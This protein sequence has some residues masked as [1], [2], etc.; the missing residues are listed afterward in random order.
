M[1]VFDSLP[2][3]IAKAWERSLTGG[4]A[5]LSRRRLL[6]ATGAAAGGAALA[7][8]GIPASDDGK[9]KG[10]SKDP[11][12][13]KKEKELIF[14]NWT[15]YIDVDDKDENKRP[16]LD[17]FQKESGIKVKYNEDVND[18]VEF[19]GKIRPQLEA[20]QSTGRDIICFS[21]F[22]AGRLIRHGW[23]QRLDPKNMPNVVTNMEPRFR[24]AAH[25]PGRQY[26][27]PWAGLATVV[28]YN[29]KATKGRKV[30]SVEQLLTDESLKGKAAMLTEMQD[31]VGMTLLDM[32]KDCTKFTED[33]FD[34]AVARIQ[35]A[36]DN[37][38]LRRFTGNDYVEELDKGD[39]AACL[40]W[41][42]DVVQMQFENPDIEFVIPQKGYLY[43]TDDLLVPA[44][45]RHKAN[46]EA[47]MDFYYDP[48][49]AAELAAWVNYICP[50]AGAKEELAKIDKELAADPLIIPDEKMIKAGRVFMELDDDAETTYEDKFSKVIGA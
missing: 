38:Q 37:K 22:M 23:A 10:E 17:R 8:C 49:N 50:V 30:T 19:F 47:L 33:E 44:K 32:G 24:N 6:A 7:A 34:A 27:V 31:T 35:K 4:K 41:A 26:T 21:D 9:K 12:Y 5:A 15:L 46:A 39:I 20:G 48:K 14:S 43:A 45:A 40:A 29:K 28:A 11:D 3:P 42:G 2:E 16:T 13:S 18:N 25:D 1:D 36:V